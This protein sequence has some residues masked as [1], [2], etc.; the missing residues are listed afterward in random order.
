MKHTKFELGCTCKDC[1]ARY[2][3]EHANSCTYG[4]GKPLVPPPSQCVKMSAVSLPAGVVKG[5][6]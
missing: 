2:Y 6:G 3:T 4:K 1:M 5:Q